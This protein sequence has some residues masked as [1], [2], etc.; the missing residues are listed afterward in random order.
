MNNTNLVNLPYLLLGVLIFLIIISTLFIKP[1]IPKIRVH[2]KTGEGK[3]WDVFLPKD[4]VDKIKSSFM[5]GLIEWVLLV[6]TIKFIAPTYWDIW[7]G[8]TWLFVLSNIVVLVIL[9]GLFRSPKATKRFAVIMTILIVAI[10]GNSYLEKLEDKGL[11]SLSSSSSAK[12]AKHK[13]SKKRVRTAP[14]WD[15]Y[16]PKILY[17]SPKGRKIDLRRGVFQYDCLSPGMAYTG[18]GASYA[19]QTPCGPYVDHSKIR[20]NPLWII[21]VPDEGRSMKVV[22]GYRTHSH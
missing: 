17:V 4:I 16:A 22:F 6:F 5:M 18:T 7:W 8:D 10:L 3:W 21:F 14:N 2:G 20:G 9:T 15:S 12:V 1:K 13:H 11:V 19:Y